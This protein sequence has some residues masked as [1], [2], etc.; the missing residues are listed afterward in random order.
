MAHI[1]D[2]QEF[3]PHVESE[4][5]ISQWPVHKLEEIVYGLT[6]ATPAYNQTTSSNNK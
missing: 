5:S 6:F 1:I 2:F 4:K 3:Q